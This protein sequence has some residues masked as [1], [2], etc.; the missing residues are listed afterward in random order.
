M[1]AQ[2]KKCSDIKCPIHG[3][4]RV[5]GRYFEGYVE[6]IV[7][8]RAVVK[9]ERIRYIQK[10]ERYYRTYS[11]VHAYLPECI[12]VQ[13]GDLVKIGECRPLSTIMHFAVLEVVK[14]ETKK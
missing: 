14:R 4:L 12:N 10:Y 5:R 9:W 13:K 3:S 6:K 11:K 8:R 2:E 1:K 7:G